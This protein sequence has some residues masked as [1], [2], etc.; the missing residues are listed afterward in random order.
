MTF[1]DTKAHYNC[2]C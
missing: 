2:C 1:K